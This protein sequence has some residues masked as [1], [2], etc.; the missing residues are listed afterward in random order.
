VVDWSAR[1]ERSRAGS[2]R[3]RCLSVSPAPLREAPRLGRAQDRHHAAGATAAGTAAAIVA[4]GDA[5]PPSA[6][7]A[8]PSQ[9]YQP[10]RDWV[11]P[12]SGE[13]AIGHSLGTYKL[14]NSDANARREGSGDADAWFAS[15][16]HRN[17]GH[18]VK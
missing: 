14:S 17:Y 1:L 15:I 18:Q 13:P 2:H 11:A 6:P 12:Q 10:A 5:V 9:T 4:A 8:S 3:G 16:C 7:A